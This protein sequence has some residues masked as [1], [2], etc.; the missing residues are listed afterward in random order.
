[1]IL[2][3]VTGQA[4]ERQEASEQARLLRTIPSNWTFDRGTLGPT[5][6]S[7]FDLS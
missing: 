7:P 4:F 5:F 1:V 2:D 3:P 6:S